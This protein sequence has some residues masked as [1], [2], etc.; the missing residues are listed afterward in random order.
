M[1]DRPNSLHNTR[2]N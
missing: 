2:Q 1:Y